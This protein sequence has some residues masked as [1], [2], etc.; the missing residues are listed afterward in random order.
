[1]TRPAYARRR[2]LLVC[3]RDRLGRHRAPVHRAFD[4][5]FDVVRY[6]VEDGWPASVEQL[7]GYD[8][9]EAIVWWVRFRRLREHPPV[10]WGGYQ[11][12]RVVYDW[13]VFQNYWHIGGAGDYRGMYAD[14]F[15]RCAFHL[16]ACTG[17]ETAARLRAE[18]V[19][20]VWIP[21][22]FDAEDFRDLGLARSGICHFGRLYPARRAM[23]ASVRGR[24]LDVTHI[25]PSY[26]G[27]NAALNRFEAAI[28]CNM[29]ASTSAGWRRWAASVV[30]GFPVRVRPGPEA[31]IKNFEVAA[32]GCALVCDEVPD[33]AH[34]GFVDGVTALTYRTFDEL[35]A[36]LEA[37]LAATD[38]FKTI[39]ARGRELCLARHTWDQRMA[40]LSEA[41]GAL[42]EQGLDAGPRAGAQPA[43]ADRSPGVDAR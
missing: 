15:K 36:K 12:A 14:V 33:L 28:V 9:Y 20:A 8:G 34:L 31:L 25:A 39:G 3:H 42:R 10:D 32:S 13:D 19:P 29:S 37:G 30:P 41:I 21:K 17:Y 7:P 11:G 35:C 23:L 4:R 43:A 27:L 24:G 40:Q 16:V 22:G 1:M 38:G 18:G 26:E 5:R 6:F 2:I